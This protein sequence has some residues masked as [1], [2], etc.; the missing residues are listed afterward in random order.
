MTETVSFTDLTRDALRNV[1]YNRSVFWLALPAGILISIASYTSSKAELILSGL[2]TENISS[3]FSH[4][5]ALDLVPL[6]LIGLIVLLLQAPLRGL[7]LFFLQF[8]HLKQIDPTHPIAQKKDYWRAMRTGFLFEG[9]YWTA[10]STIG[11][12]IIAPCI[13]ASRVNPSVFPS[14]LQIGFLLFIGTALYLYLIKELSLLYGL[15][16]KISLRSSIDLGF[17]I[18][19]RYSFLTLLYFTY[20][21]ILSFLT[22]TL[23][24]VFIQIILNLIISP[25]SDTFLF[26]LSMPFLGMYF[27]FDQ[28]LRLAYFRKIASTPKSKS[29]KV[30]VPKPAEAATGVNNI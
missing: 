10:L 1:L 15:F 11:L 3:L 24:T 21:S 6:I 9:I 18:F 5:T 2:K 25:Q 8:F 26:I 12:I 16:G 19:R 4:P 22:T 28:S 27:V 7:T 20:L 30:S 23:F 17:R 13:V 29:A 14:I